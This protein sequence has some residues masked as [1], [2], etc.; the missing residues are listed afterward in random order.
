M[1]PRLCV[2]PIRSL[3][4]WERTYDW[5]SG[6]SQHHMGWGLCQP[7]FWEGSGQVASRL[8]GFAVTSKT[9]P[10]Q[11]TGLDGGK[12]SPCRNQLRKIQYLQG[13]ALSKWRISIIWGS[14]EA[15]EPRTWCV[16]KP[17]GWLLMPGQTGGP[18]QLL[19]EE[20]EGSDWSPLCVEKTMFSVLFRV[21]A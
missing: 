4:F 10:W 5:P 15:P 1:T 17:R 18:L 13:Q 16:E 12:G 11:C 3:N 21:R 14:P 20:G 6:S 9:N 8:H 19:R 2:S 7:G